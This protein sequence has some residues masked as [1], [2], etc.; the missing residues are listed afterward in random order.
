MYYN[1]VSGISPEYVE[2]PPNQGM[3]I[4]LLHPSISSDQR[5]LSLFLSLDNSL[6]TPFTEPGPEIWE[7]STVIARRQLATAPY[8]MFVTLTEA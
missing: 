7:V 3:K 8:A 4:G 2:F 6:A 1:Q 5:L